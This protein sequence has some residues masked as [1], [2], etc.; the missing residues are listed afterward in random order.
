ME[1]QNATTPTPPDPSTTDHYQVRLIQ[2]ADNQAVKTVIQEVM[3]TLGCQGPGWACSDPEI[4]VMWETYQAPRSAYWVIEDTRTGEIVGTGG[5]SQLKGTT[6][7]ENICEFQ[8]FYL[9]PHVR[10]LGLGKRIAQWAIEGAR[11]D[12]YALIYLE[13]TEV[14]LEAHRLYDRLGFQRIDTH[15][16]A[17]GHH[18]NCRIRM[19]LPL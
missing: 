10:G 5:Y 19:T 4:E 2:Q 9:R 18:E 11:K 12:G 1:L 14:M 7:E 3:A 15:L 8:K 6:D 16:G 17:T 13:T